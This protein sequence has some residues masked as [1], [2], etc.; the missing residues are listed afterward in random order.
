VE[1]VHDLELSKYPTCRRRTS[2][3]S[4]VTN[5][6]SGP[7]GAVSGLQNSRKVHAFSYQRRLRYGG[8]SNPNWMGGWSLR[9]AGR[10]HHPDRPCHSLGVGLH[11]R[12]F[13]RIG[14]NRSIGIIPAHAPI[15]RWEMYRKWYGRCDEHGSNDRRDEK[16]VQNDILQ[17]A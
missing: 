15:R 2:K 9:H 3:C 16:R 5:V 13:E 10:C 6:I 17:E 1:L 7:V 12:S 14:N 4:T 8:L 11:G